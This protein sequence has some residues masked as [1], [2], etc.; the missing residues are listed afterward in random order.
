MFLLSVRYSWGWAVLQPL[1]PSWGQR[2]FRP[3]LPFAGR[4]L[5]LHR[6]FRLLCFR[7]GLFAPHRGRS[8]DRG[9]HAVPGMAGDNRDL[10]AVQL[11][12][13]CQIFLFLRGAEADG[14]AVGTG[15][16]RAANA[17]DVGLRHLG[18]VVV[19]HMRQ[20]ADVNAAGGDIGRH[21]HP[22]LTGL[23]IL[24]RRSRGRSGSCCRG[25]RQ[26]GCP[27]C[28][29]LLQFYRLRAWCG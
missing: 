16:G 5:C 9:G 8:L 21:Q 19:E 22:G 6:L 15:T 13:P 7:L 1:F 18:Q 14:S 24:Q 23:E 29:D 25:W 17:V 28:S 27:A 11:F 2:A 20:L 3:W 26:P 12:D 10:A 4:L